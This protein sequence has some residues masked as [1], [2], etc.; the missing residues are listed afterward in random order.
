M[1]S[2]ILPVATHHHQKQIVP[3][4]LRAFLDAWQWDLEE[5]TGVSWHCSGDSPVLVVSEVQLPA[6]L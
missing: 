6:E 5:G 1:G 3:D 4:V 2:W